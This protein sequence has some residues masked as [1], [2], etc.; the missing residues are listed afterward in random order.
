MSGA[1]LFA[2]NLRRSAAI[3]RPG[4]LI[5]AP[6][7]A[8]RLGPASHQDSLGRDSV[9]APGPARRRAATLNALDDGLE[10]RAVGSLRFDTSF[11]LTT[12]A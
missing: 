10:R 11:T 3:L 5:W 9:L 12:V 6:D 4:P 8:R 2:R 7:A 1:L